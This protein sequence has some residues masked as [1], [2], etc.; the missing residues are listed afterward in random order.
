MHGVGWC[1][2]AEINR[3]TAHELHISDRDE[4]WVESQ[5][6][7]L[8]LKARVT[9]WVNPGVVAVAHGQGHYA[10]GKWQ[11]G[12]GVNPSDIVGMDFDRL[13]GQSALFNT[14]V[15]VYRT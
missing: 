4:V 12:I 1:N 10:P 15:K 7:R 9:D 11:Q 2:F 3:E 5:F 14:R 8:K 6:G 13:S